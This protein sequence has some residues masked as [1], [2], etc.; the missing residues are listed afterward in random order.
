VGETDKGGPV[1]NKGTTSPTGDSIPVVTAP[2]QYTIPL[3]TPFALTGNATDA[4]G[5]VLTYS[6]EQ[7][8]RGASP[9]AAGTALMS[10]IK[11]NGPLFAMFPFSGQIS[12]ADSL[13]YNSPG[14]NHLTNDPTRVFPDLQQILDNNTNADTGSCAQ[15]P[16][17]P[18]VPQGITECYAEFLPTSDYVGV[19]GV[20]ADPLALHMRFTA[21]DGRGGSNFAD[22]TLLLANTAGPFLVTSPN[23]AVSLPG[24]ST[25][26]VTWN[27]AG[28]DLAPVNTANVKISLSVDSGHTYPYVLA[29]STPNTGSAS[30]VLPMVGTTHA[31]V[32]VEAV[33]NVFFDVSNADFA[34][35]WPF[36]GYFPPIGGGVNSAKAGS[37]VPVKFSLGGDR[38]LAILAD[39]Y[40]ASVQINCT[41]GA[42]IGSPSPTSSDEGL[43]F[44]DGQY[45]YVW[46][47]SGSWAG[48]CRQFQILLV[49]GTL[50]TARFSF[51]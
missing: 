30:V 37:A 20:N 42:P 31:R 33:D 35:T 16:I 40:P 27:V 29:G 43:T 9:N 18:P 17:A 10:N 47:T 32:K 46:K 7:N 28:T 6:W 8:D 2:A 34:I 19:A 38:G 51:K 36:S 48:T 14:E 1:D 49:D 13:L 12:D 50:H 23:T 24:E 45:K 11:T 26:T 39:G 21:R 22:T 15:G 41:T 44:Q 25:Q 5:D 3:R 4:N